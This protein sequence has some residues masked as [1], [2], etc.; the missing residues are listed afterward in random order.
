MMDAPKV[1]DVRGLTVRLPAGADRVNAIEDL[2]LEIREREIVCVVGESGSGKS[3]TAFSIMGLLPKGQ[4]VPTA[5][6]I[7]VQGEDVLQAT[8]ARRARRASSSCSTPC[9]CPSPSGCVTPIRTSSRAAS[10]S[11]S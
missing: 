3:V 10:A 7:R 6:E 9:A 2:D 4:L 8:T 11:A 5:G 1:L